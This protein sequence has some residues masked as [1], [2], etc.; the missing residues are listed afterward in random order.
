M[1][2]SQAIKVE[3]ERM[4]RQYGVESRVTITD[5]CEP[6][7]LP[8]LYAAAEMLVYPSLFEG[9]GLPPLEA[10]SCGTPVVASEASAIP[11]VVGDDALLV[12]PFDATS[13]ATAIANLLHDRELW[14][15]LAVRGVERARRFS[16][17]RTARET[18]ETL[19]LAVRRHGFRD[20]SVTA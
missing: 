5:Y 20:S 18:R 8:H 6:D 1:P 19:E 7:V 9:F 12:D 4:L 2:S 10:M 16:W 11:E 14:C 17:E 3:V 13:I 15:Q